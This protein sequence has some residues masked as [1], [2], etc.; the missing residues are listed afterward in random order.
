MASE[1]DRHHSADPISHTK[2]S[3]RETAGSFSL[4]APMT[5]TYSYGKQKQE[6]IA[7]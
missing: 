3:L 1:T 6:K 4:I 7:L 5:T 2:N